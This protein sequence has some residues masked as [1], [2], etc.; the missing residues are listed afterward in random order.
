MARLRYY[1][2]IQ[3]IDSNG[4]LKPVPSATVTVYE[5]GTT[6]P[7]AQTIY[8]GNTGGTT[9]S[10]P[11]T[12]GS[13]GSVE[14]YLATAQR[15]KIRSTG[16]GLGTTDLDL[17]PPLHDPSDVVDKTST[18]TLTNKTLTSPV[19]NTPT[20]DVVTLTGS[21]TL[22][23]KVL[24]SPTVTGT[25]TGGVI[26]DKGGMVQ[27]ASAYGT[28]SQ[29]TL[30]GTWSGSDNS[31]T[32]NAAI[33]GAVASGSNAVYIPRGVYG[34]SSGLNCTNIP[35]GITIIADNPSNT[36]L[37][38]LS[39]MA[40]KT[41]FDFSGSGSIKMFGLGIGD[42]ANASNPETAIVFANSST[43]TSASNVHYLQNVSIS[44]SYTI[45][46]VYA[47]AMVSSRFVDCQ[48]INHY[49]SA[50][51]PALY[52]T[53]SN[54]ASVASDFVTISATG[55]VGEIGFFGCEVHDVSKSSGASVAYAAILDGTYS[56]TFSGGN[57]GGNGPRLIDLYGTNTNLS[58]LSG[59][60]YAQDPSG[61]APTNVLYL[62]SGASLNGLVI[63]G[64]RLDAG[65]AVIGGAS[66]TTITRPFTRANTVNTATSFV[67]FTTSGNLVEPDMDCHGLA[68]NCGSGAI[69]RGFLL[70]PGTVTASGG[71]SSTRLGS[72]TLTLASGGVTASN[73]QIMASNGTAS[74]GG[75]T[76]GSGDARLYRSG[77][78]ELSI[79]VGGGQIAKFNGSGFG[80]AGG[81]IYAN[82]QIA[83]A[84]TGTP[85]DFNLGNTGTLKFFNNSATGWITAV[86]KD[87][88]DN[89][90]FGN[91][92]LAS[93]VNFVAANTLSF[94]LGAT[95][96][97]QCGALGS[98]A[99]V[100]FIA[101]GTAPSSNP[102][103]GGYLYVESGALK[104]RG[105]S[106][107][108]TTLGAA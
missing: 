11:M 30:S 6:T 57:V 108:V 82:G 12:A 33:A 71:D 73:G 41:M 50:G 79:S 47:C 70:N 13:D 63:Q 24:S 64:C 49:D 25:L 101:N 48:I 68:V 19:I 5:P 107:T 93:G 62:E 81:G 2:V 39:G 65:T 45:A 7:L 32:L 95:T 84:G 51:V 86:T 54:R 100:W 26:L 104:Y 80:L 98:G 56:I 34:I 35:G 105:S 76:F 97:M 44:G 43:Y 9:K 77:S 85:G 55:G 23:N 37:V 8:A 52:L 72:G 83:N 92:S 103:S 29:A 60:Y 3:T 67:A 36:R 15:V 38:A 42:T 102:A 28:M 46:A 1:T 21:Q 22:T 99:R 61:T 78:N 18:Q 74:S 69:T 75:Y 10:N 88:S 90:T 59:V 53:A 4:F 17:E 20:G 58:L 89:L 66:G 27:H 91:A 40:G 94:L 16:S 106:G 96:V 14:F 87:T 31:T